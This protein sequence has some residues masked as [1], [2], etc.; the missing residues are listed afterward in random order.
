MRPL[1]LKVAAWAGLTTTRCPI[2]ASL[3]DRADG[4]LCRH[5]AEELAPRTGGYCP[6]CGD[7]FGDHNTPPTLC[8]E[9]HTTP[10]PWDRLHFHNIHA[11]PL[12]DLILSYKFNNGIGRTRLLSTLALEALKKDETRI[13]DV[14]IPV[15]LHNKRLLW[16][17][18]NQST[19]IALA[20]GKAL[21][22]PVLK[23]GLIRTRNTKPQTRLGMQERQANIKDAFKAK[24]D[25]VK[26]ASVLLVDDVYTTGAT[27]QECAR[28]LRKAK[29]AGVDVLVLARAIS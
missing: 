7:I 22:R 5:C 13:P 25:S 18:Y 6:R 21:D 8:G 26:G 2:C 17:G 3:T 29:V 16:R 14:I 10:P 20:V 12:R 28:T 24:A 23:N 1:F 4:E 15:P 27:M 11:G 9:C 19:E